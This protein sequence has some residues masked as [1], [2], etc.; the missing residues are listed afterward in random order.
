MSRRSFTLFTLAFSARA[1]WSMTGHDALRSSTE[2]AT[3]PFAPSLAPLLSSPSPARARFAPLAGPTSVVDVTACNV[4]FFLR[5]AG[6]A[7]SRTPAAAWSPCAGGGGGGGD[8]PQVVAGAA[9]ARGGRECVVTT[10][11]RNGTALAWGVSAAGDASLG[12]V[13]WS[14][15]LPFPPVADALVM[16]SSCSIVWMSQTRGGMQSLFFVM[17]AGVACDGPI[18]TRVVTRA[19]ALCGGGAAADSFVAPLAA[20]RDASNSFSGFLTV[21]AQ[22]AVTAA[23]TGGAIVWSSTQ[24]CG[25]KFG[26]SVAAPPVVAADSSAAFI[27]SADGYVCCVDVNNSSACAAWA[28][29][30]EGGLPCTLLPSPTPPLAP[31]LALSPST[32]DFHGGSLYAA[33]SAG[34]VFVVNAASGVAGSSGGDAFGTP[35]VVN[36]PPVLI[37]GHAGEQYDALLLIGDAPPGSLGPPT[38]SAFLVGDNGANGDDNA[39]DDD[40]YA[41][42]GPLWSLALAL[43]SGVAEGLGGGGA[44]AGV[45]VV[46]D[47]TVLVS[48]AAGLWAV[49]GNVHPDDVPNSDLEIVAFSS[50]AAGV[51]A[52]GIV[53]CVVARQRSRRIARARAAAEAL[54][55]D[56]DEGEWDAPSSATPH[57]SSSDS[58]GAAYAELA[59]AEEEEPTGRKGGR[60]FAL[61]SIN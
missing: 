12:S 9:L 21:S 59:A 19:A 52:L 53:L 2:T 4:T 13:V 22:G 34:T 26:G 27:L 30:S 41:T 28:A 45:A 46:G 35:V 38:L 56:G 43:G 36:A 54:D 55:A 51:A 39:V 11:F 6:G 3:V 8:A 44:S 10:A 14:V 31:G 61:N 47:A 58:L 40:N 15:S 49:T 24:L 50:I 16:D 33:D 18:E 25:A 17:R 20:I 42:I 57:A 48:T 5:G 29:G 7:V 37:V 23:D 60:V 32:F 1:L